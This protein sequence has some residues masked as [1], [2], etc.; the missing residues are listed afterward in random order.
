M[1]DEN[2]I[3]KKYTKCNENA[4]KVSN[5][6]TN[7]YSNCNRKRNNIEKSLEHTKKRWNDED[8]ETLQ[9][10]IDE[11]NS[12]LRSVNENYLKYY[13]YKLRNE[14]LSHEQTIKYFRLASY[15]ARLV[16]KSL[17]D[18]FERKEIKDIILNKY[19]QKLTQ[20]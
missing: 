5:V 14:N 18:F 12:L 17:L 6:F 4:Q 11:M 19:Y 20:K 9:K 13:V 8:P 7:F 16:D 15:T 2:H 3:I 10:K 1:I